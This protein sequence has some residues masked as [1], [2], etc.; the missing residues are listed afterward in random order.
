MPSTRIPGFIR[1][2]CKAALVTALGCVVA[3]LVSAVV[4][5]VW[6]P[7]VIKEN[8]PADWSLDGLGYPPNASL[9]SCTTADGVT[10]KGF[11]VPADDGAPL[12]VHFAESGSSG[13]DGAFFRRQYEGLAHVGFASLVMDYRGIGASEGERTPSRLGED[14]AAI[15][16]HARGLVGGDEARLL[17]RG[18]SLGA[19]A[20]A[21]LLEGGARP[22]AVVAW[23]PVEARDVA[24]RF[25]AKGDWGHAAWLMAPF[26]R[27]FESACTTDQLL[28][29]RCPVFVGA[30]PDDSLL[31]GAELARFRAASE[32]GRVVLHVPAHLTEG[33]KPAGLSG[34]GAIASASYWISPAETAF[35]HDAFPDEPAAA[36][37][38]YRL[39]AA[40]DTAP[41][42]GVPEEPRFREALESIASFRQDMWPAAAVAAAAVLPEPSLAK[43]LEGQAKI[44]SEGWFTRWLTYQDDASDAAAPIEDRLP[45]L[46]EMLAVFKADI[47]DEAQG[48]M[49]GAVGTAQ[50]TLRLARSSTGEA[51]WTPERLLALVRALRGDTSDP[52]VFDTSSGDVP[53]IP[54]PFAG[55]TVERG[56]TTDE[57]PSVSVHMVLVSNRR[58]SKIPVNPERLFASLGIRDGA[59]TPAEERRLLTCLLRATWH[60]HEVRP[61]PGGDWLIMKRDPAESR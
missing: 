51:L 14:A 11:F 22:G 53:D 4:G 35:L 42:G 47:G 60:S 6:V 23:A 8:G 15:Y 3:A 45:G 56:I 57:E 27:E 30:S 55:L 17:L 2:P 32:A 50:G 13:F 25:A 43:V 59:I 46:N 54:G 18:C 28:E 24:R 7:P 5:G 20:A 40:V 19:V 36:R 12:V 9:T 41:L 48:I 52:F 61:D 39:L 34:H 1:L 49:L 33:D 26:L 16:A 10:L 44:C 38:A 31:A 29:A 37:R 21:S 58:P